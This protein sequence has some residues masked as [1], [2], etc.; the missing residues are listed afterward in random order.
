M[1]KAAVQEKLKDILDVEELQLTHPGYFQK[2]TTAAKQVLDEMTELERTVIYQIVED[3]RKNGNPDN[4]RRERVSL[5]S[6][7][8]GFSNFAAGER[9]HIVKGNCKNGQPSGG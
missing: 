1:H 2:R 9:K 6:P 4:I 8:S 5:N 3:R 7:E